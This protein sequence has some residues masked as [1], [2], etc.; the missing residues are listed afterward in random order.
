M[1]NI[2]AEITVMAVA[3]SN[4]DSMK[5]RENHAV[6]AFHHFQFHM[7]I[8]FTLKNELWKKI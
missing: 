1:F 6:C 5:M 8:N 4:S 2:V 3:I 7:F